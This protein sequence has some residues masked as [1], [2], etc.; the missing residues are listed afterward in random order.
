ME[1]VT[2]DQEMIDG[3]E[4]GSPTQCPVARAINRH[5]GTDNAK[6][7]RELDGVANFYVHNIWL[8][9]MNENGALVAGEWIE[10]FDRGEPVEPFQILVLPL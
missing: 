9:P 1:L 6:V 8:Q 7:Y 4:R 5:W 10:R 2:I 3:A